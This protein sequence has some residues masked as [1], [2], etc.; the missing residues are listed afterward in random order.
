M[1]DVLST[2]DQLVVGADSEDGIAT[3]AGAAYVFMRNGTT[4]SQTAYLKASDAAAG[5]YF[6]ASVGI[7]GDTLVV[8]ARGKTST[9]TE[10]GV[11]FV[12]Q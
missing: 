4:W 8:G 5:D 3:D 6:G 10:S 12:F 9:V 7:D 2:G 11:A 1:L